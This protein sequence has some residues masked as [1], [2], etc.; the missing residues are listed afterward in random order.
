MINVAVWQLVLYVLAGVALGAVA[1]VLSFTRG[2]QATG[3]PPTPQTGNVVSDKGPDPAAALVAAA[4]R[5]DKVASFLKNRVAKKRSVTLDEAAKCLDVSPR[6][7]R[8]LLDDNVLMAIPTPGG[9]RL[10]SAVSVLDVIARRE[11]ALAMKEPLTGIGQE[12]TV[13]PLAGVPKPTREPIG[14]FAKE[15]TDDE[16]STEIKE[17]AEDKEPTEKPTEEPTETTKLK[18]GP[19]QSYWYH[20]AGHDKPLASI[21]DALQV[22]GLDYKYTGWKDIPAYI[23]S[24]M[25]REKVE[26]V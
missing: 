6:R 1:V 14:E 7:I 13:R 2:K 12:E 26:K 5:R 11:A 25:R 15:L 3:L 10:V 16:E 24:K 17:S 9:G 23:R 22:L 8:R 4:T 21:R 20:V 19:N 18:P